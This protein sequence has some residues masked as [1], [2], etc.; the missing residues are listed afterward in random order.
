MVETGPRTMPSAAFAASN[1][2]SGNVVP[3][4]ANDTKPIS[5][6]VKVKFRS[7]QSSTA[8]KTRRVAAVISGPI[9][10]P[11]RHNICTGSKL[12]FNADIKGCPFLSRR[13]IRSA[14][15]A[16]LDGRSIETNQPENLLFIFMSKINYIQ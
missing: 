6:E 11:S 1:T 9:P 15:V 2:L 7:K 12:F 10:S 14:Y 13:L 8:C 4:A 3:D 16:G 5:S